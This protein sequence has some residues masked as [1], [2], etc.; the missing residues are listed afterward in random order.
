MNTVV[1]KAFFF[2]QCVYFMTS[3]TIVILKFLHKINTIQSAYAEYIF[4]CR[5]SNKISM[6]YPP[7]TKSRKIDAFEQE[8][9]FCHY[10]FMS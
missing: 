4:S 10:L 9:C 1:T 3:D 2:S 5:N 8:I 7:N 6:Q